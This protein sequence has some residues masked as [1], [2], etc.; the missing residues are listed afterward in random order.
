[1]GGVRLMKS[2]V[3]GFLLLFTLSV[4]CSL[5][6]E[7]AEAREAAR[8]VRV[9]FDNIL[10]KGDLKTAYGMLS[11]DTRV[12][13]L[14][15]GGEYYNSIVTAVIRDDSETLPDNV[16][17]IR[18]AV[19]E[20]TPVPMN[21]IRYEIGNPKYFN[22]SAIVPITFCVASVPE[23]DQLFDSFIEMVENNN[24]NDMTYN[25]KKETIVWTAQK[26]KSAVKDKTFEMQVKARDITLIKENGKWKLSLAESPETALKQNKTEEAQLVLKQIYIMQRTYRKQFD[27]YSEDLMALGVEIPWNARYDY[28]IVSFD[29]TTFV[30]Q[31][32]LS[33]PG[34]DDDPTP[35]TWTID[36][37]G[38]IMHV[39]NDI[40]N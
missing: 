13:W 35:D 38:S 15:Y 14:M 17:L 40:T 36:Q 2:I 29:S 8:Q 4:A 12:T 30:A 19:A 37:D 9:F 32:H 10:Q 21:L 18:E 5:S 25:M 16:K 33:S 1:M 34:V 39:S 23:L 24:F 26:I 28:S 3:L 27:T 6:K 22:D 31:A 20:F 7:E 11:A